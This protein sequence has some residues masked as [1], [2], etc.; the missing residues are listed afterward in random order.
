MYNVVLVSAVQ[1]SDLVI[2]IYSFFFRTFFSI[3]VYH[4]ILSIGASQMA[5]V[6]KNLPAR[7]GDVRDVGSVP[8]S[9]RSPGRGHGNPPQYSSLENPMGRGAFLA[10]VHGVTKSQT[11]LK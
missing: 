4:W 1:Q 9:G 2:H 7:A 5:P 11:Q 10:T 6:V 8:G 3:M